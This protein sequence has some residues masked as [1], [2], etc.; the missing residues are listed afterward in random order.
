MKYRIIALA[1]IFA[2]LASIIP[3]FGCMGPGP[4]PELE[5]MI[6]EV[7]PVTVLPEDVQ[8]L[9]LTLFALNETPA[10]NETPELYYVSV[11]PLYLECC[12][13][14]G[15]IWFADLSKLYCEACKGDEYEFPPEETA[16]AIAEVFLSELGLFRVE[17]S[18]RDLLF[19]KCAVR[20]IG[21]NETETAIHHW[22]VMFSS[23][24]PSCEQQEIIPVYGPGAKI[25]VSI[26]DEGEVIGLHYVWREVEPL[27]TYPAITE[28]EAIEI[29]KEKLGGEPEELEVKLGYY[30]ESEFTEQ[31]FLQPYYI[32]DGTVMIEE[33]EVPFKTR[34]IPATT[35][36]PTARI[37]SPDDGAEF[38]EGTMIDF[39]A[40]VSGG[41]PPYEYIWESH[42]DGVIGTGASFSSNLSV[43]QRD[44]EIL[45]H[46]IK[47]K[48][49]D[50]NGNQGIDIV[51]VKVIPSS[52]MGSAP[53]GIQ[54]LSTGSP[55]DDMNDE[56]VG[57]EWVNACTV[58]PLT[59]CDENARGFRDELVA[60]GWVSEFECGEE[61]AWEEDFKF[62]NAPAGGTD[63][64]YID[65]VDFAFFSGEGDSRYIQFGNRSVD[66]DK[67][68]FEEARWGGDAGGT[69]GEEGDLEWI[70]LDA[71]STLWWI[72]N[73]DG[74]Y[75]FDRWDQA[76]DG[77][78]YVLGFHGS[79][80]DIPNRG[81]IFAQYMKQ[82]WTVRLA[83]IRATQA[84]EQHAWGA[85]LRAERLDPLTNTYNDHLPGHGYVSPD[86]YPVDCFVYC[87]W[88]C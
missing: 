84:T 35:F 27:E 56:E 75:V 11:E 19:G 21:T 28:D 6:Y 51:S 20:D 32:F 44:E 73:K 25:R 23:E 10:V 55:A 37:V 18:L 72:S 42:I 52:P 80:G 2:F 69:P 49:T 68:Y 71:C 26:G 31:D 62:R 29:F 33:E 87:T 57:I 45:P 46:T 41:E 17:F 36:S 61:Y 81:T 66:S 5:F 64:D 1:V 74:S 70:V 47:L 54:T 3:E 78:H 88:P 83:W 8:N 34:L 77:L 7:K 12:K 16:I 60:D 9:T 14:S 67:F 15:S 82:G 50:Q 38:P 58:P 4:G 40:S 53:E 22:D 43:G 59:K 13:N 86:P 76:F 79:C 48:V 65:A 63:F 39:G 85:Y 24:L 30:A